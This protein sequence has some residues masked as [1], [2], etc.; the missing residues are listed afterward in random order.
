MRRALLFAAIALASCNSK[1]DSGFAEVPPAPTLPVSIAGDDQKVLVGTSPVTLNGTKSYDPDGGALTFEWT[2]TAGPAV[3]LATPTAATTTFP[4]PA[5]AAVLTFRLTVTGTTGTD[6]DTVDIVVKRMTVT[7]PETWF[8]GYGKSGTIAAALDGGTGPFTWQWSGVASWITASGTTTSTL[9]YTTP[10]LT[11]LQNFPDLAGVAVCERTTQGR[12]QLT[13]QVTDTANG[14]TDSDF[15]NFSAGPFADS[16]ANENV[17]LGEPV[18][19]NGAVTN[20]SGTITSWTWIGF[21]PSGAT[22]SF[23]KPDKSPLSGA[24]DQRFVYFVPDQLG[25]YTIQVMTMPGPVTKQF[26]L[27]A[28]RYVGA[29]NL[30]GKTPDPFKGEC[31]A[32]HAGQLAFVDDFA[33]PW[34]ATGHA[35]KFE[36]LLDPAS[37]YYAAVQAKGHWLDTFNFGS[38]YGI[39]TRTVGWSRITTGTNNGWAELAAA[40]GCSLKGLTASELKRKFPRTSGMSNVQCESC[41][42]PG[43]EHAGDTTGIRKSFDA[44]VCGRCHSRKQDLWEASGH[45]LPPTASASGNASCNGCHTAQG[46]VVE[47]RAQEGADP[48]TALYAFSNLNRPVIPYEDRR[49]TTCQ[50][51]HDPH[52][53]TAKMGSTGPDPQ[54]RAFG[55]VKFRN[56]AIVNAGQAAVCYECHN[57]RTDARDNSG[58]MNIRRA[59]HDSTASE[60]L[61]GVNG[62]HVPGWTYA[63]SPHGIPSRFIKPGATENR[64]CLTCHADV[65]PGP[66]AVGYNALGGHTFRMDQGSGTAIAGD[67][68]HPGGGT[69]AGSR[70]FTVASGPTFLKSV[71]PGDTLV[72]AAGSDAGTYTVSSVDNARKLTLGTGPNFT[73]GAATSWSLTS[74]VKYN[75]A[76]CTQCHTT[77]TGFENQARA[78]YDGD[79][80]LET[81]QQEMAGLQAALL[82]AI[83]AKLATLVAPGFT[84]TISQGR[85]RYTNGSVTRVFPGPGVT[86]SENPDI[87]WS[88]LT[89]AQQAEW[90][91]LYRAAY[92]RTYVM[93]DKSSG[94]HNTGYAV[95]LLQSSY[96]AVTGSTIGAPFVPY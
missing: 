13:V 36:E 14:D 61:G 6:T 96:F 44:S 93:N 20:T 24:T 11:D 55:N 86:T 65:Q 5:S 45:G 16:V 12:L 9:A 77:G 88:S 82:T 46:F 37:P 71:V 15:V 87:P 33:T 84:L 38:N 94:I 90:L 23:L 78:D 19:M 74:V 2:Q 35:R 26:E 53:R 79:T 18:F 29:G 56:D 54:L 60:M 52:K 47:M 41:H 70:T 80:A 22:V 95:N 57:S 59:P 62:S 83:N 92:N 50:A 91:A 39:E 34:L 3:T 21:K 27:N 69:V 81:V 68:Q 31:A 64:Q 67:A 76:A 85:V 25:T 7:A 51:C 49:G 17:A 72:I 10:A 73:G 58:D 30:L 89:P 4:A 48:H 28:G 1:S 63:S 75:T 66:G 43:S 40:E 8:V 42:G 32:C